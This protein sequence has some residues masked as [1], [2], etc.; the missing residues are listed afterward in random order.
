MTFQFK[1]HDVVL[2]QSKSLFMF[3]VSPKLNKER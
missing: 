2:G 1:S 3:D